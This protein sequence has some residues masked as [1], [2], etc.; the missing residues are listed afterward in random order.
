MAPRATNQKQGGVAI[1]DVAVGLVIAAAIGVGVYVTATMDK[2]ATNT[3]RYSLRDYDQRA[4]ELEKVDP[5]LIIYSEDKTAKISTGLQAAKA[6]A[7]TPSGGVVVVGDGLVRRYDSHGAVELEFK[8]PNPPLCVAVDADGGL[9]VGYRDHMIAYDAKGKELRRFPGMG[10]D[11]RF[12]SIALTKETIFVADVGMRVVHH[13]SREGEKIGQ[14]GE[15]PRGVEGGH[16]NIPSPYFDLAVHEGVLSVVNPGVHT[17]ETYRDDRSPRSTFGRYGA[18][19]EGFCGCC[20]PVNI[21]MLPDGNYVTSEK[22]L[23][24]IKVLSED[25]KLIGVV[26]APKDFKGLDRVCATK[27]ADGGCSEGGL[28]IATD[29]KGRVLVLDPYSGE[30]RV[31]VPNAAK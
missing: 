16:F 7:T 20:N 19:I 14:I 18:D 30:V 9:F 27:E 5:A 2:N 24:R 1:V 15:K 28:D 23:T 13:F 21:A 31:F 3:K 8:A 12:S 17:I 26:A 11:A 22:G 10:E 6:L 29:A 25:G 4:A